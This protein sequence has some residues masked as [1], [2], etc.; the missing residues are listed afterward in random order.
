VRASAAGL[1]GRVRWFGR[2]RQRLG[3]NDVLI[4]GRELQAPGGRRFELRNQRLLGEHNA[5]NAAAAVLACLAW[6]VADDAL[7]SGLDDYPGLPH[8]IEPVAEIGG[9]LFVDDS[10]GTNL[11]A[12]IKSLTCFD[13]PVVLIAGG[14]G[15]G[16]GY[17]P[18]RE[19]V[20]RRV[21]HLVLIGEEAG[22]LERD[23]AGCAP[24]SRAGS[25]EEAVAEAAA[26][27]SPG[28]VVLLSPACASFDMFTDYH[29]R[30]QAF[31]AAVLRLG[32]KK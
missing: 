21:K 8:R 24:I 27:A 19:A 30:G 22:R 1:P 28:E 12:T 14:R 6:K 10:K 15:K 2:Q 17:R 16:T 5:E 31:A 18:L 3:E 25:M 11:D 26:Q 13:R 29:H 4:R 23:L 9:V 20:S 32:E 7:Q